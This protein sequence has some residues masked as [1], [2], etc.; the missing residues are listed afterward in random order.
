M[1]GISPGR[2]AAAIDHTLLR[3][4]AVPG[5][6][7]ALCDEAVRY[8]FAGV[9]VN[10]IYVPLAAA[11]LAGTGVRVCCVVGFPLGASMPAVKAL[12][13]ETAVRDGA[14][15]LDLVIDLSA[16]RAGDHGRI[17]AE[18][19]AVQS[20]ARRG[21]REGR[22][23]FDGQGDSPVGRG[24]TP[25]GDT[26]IKAILETGLLEPEQVRAA[27]QAALAG[28]AGFLK[29]STGLGPRGATAEDVR[30]L[31][32]IAGNTYG[33]KAAG[34][35]RDA[36]RARELLAAGADRLGT[37]AGVAIMSSLQE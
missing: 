13:A 37:S 16:A 9:C 1:S 28:G 33:V 2:L 20:A 6:V 17:E 21:L 15:E 8:G 11:R 3:A 22:G 4:G 36:V 19:A 34:G 27:A 12:E 29:T 32:E 10:P 30:L 26:L 18:V 23:N 5:E 14:H 31:R 7:A 25:V 35:I 24:D